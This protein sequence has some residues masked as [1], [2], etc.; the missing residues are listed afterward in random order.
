MLVDRFGWKLLL[1]FTVNGLELEIGCGQAD[2]TRPSHE[3]DKTES[4]GQ[5]V[6]RSS[7]A[8]FA[9]YLSLYV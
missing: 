9:F 7:S 3:L 8:P 1:V 6:L 4:C 2:P 5:K